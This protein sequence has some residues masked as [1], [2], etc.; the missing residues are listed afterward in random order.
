MKNQRQNLDKNIDLIIA[1]PGR[2]LHH[3]NSE[4]LFTSR[5]RYFVIDEA[6]SLLDKDFGKDIDRILEILGHPND[7]KKSKFNYRP[8][9]IIVT[10]ALTS[11]LEKEIDTRWKVCLNKKTIFF[12]C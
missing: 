4:N 8:Q 11:K 2:L 10:A 3:K 1:T 9:S 5:V 12:F 6:D 7:D